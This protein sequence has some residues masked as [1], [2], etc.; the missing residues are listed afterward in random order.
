MNKCIPLKN[1]D[2]SSLSRILMDLSS[3]N[4]E[5]SIA[6]KTLL[7]L[8]NTQAKDVEGMSDVLKAREETINLVLAE[9]LSEIIGEWLT[10]ALGEI[11]IKSPP[12]RKLPD[13][14]FVEYYGMKIAFEAKIGLTNIRY[15]VEKCKQRVKEGLADI[16]FAVAYDE[17]VAKVEKIEEVK[18]KLLTNPLRLVII[19]ASNL[20]GI[21]LG[22]VKL[23]EFVSTLERHRIYDHLISKEISLEIASKLK[24]ILDKTTHLPNDLLNN[25]AETVEHELKLMIKPPTETE[26]ED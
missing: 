24:N 19:S 23:E 3:L 21:D 18:E 17:E 7:R 13:I 10:I 6:C 9:L 15:A 1:E 5:H 14:Y 26:E 12:K 22:E 2:K 20:E 25:I 11:V 4:S 8:Y 16:C